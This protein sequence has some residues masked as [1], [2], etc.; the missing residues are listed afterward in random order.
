ML[1]EHAEVRNHSPRSCEVVVAVELAADFAD[2]FA[3][4]GGAAVGA[5]CGFVAAYAR[6]E[7]S[8]Q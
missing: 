8:P 2:V 5:A 7:R 1:R 4:I 3:G 6:R